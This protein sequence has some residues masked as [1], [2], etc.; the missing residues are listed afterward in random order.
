MGAGFSTVTPSGGS[1]NA[2]SVAQAVWSYSPRSLTDIQS[3]TAAIQN[4]DPGAVPSY[5]D[6]QYVP[7]P[8]Y[9]G[10]VSLTQVAAFMD[11]AIRNYN[12]AGAFANYIT[13]NPYN[14]WPPNAVGAFL[15]SLNMSQTSVALLLAY[16]G[17]TQMGQALSYLS[18]NYTN[19]AAVFNIVSPSTGATVMANMNAS[20]AAIILS[21]PVMSVTQAAMILANPVIP[22]AVGANILNVMA[23]GTAAIIFSNPNMSVTQAAMYLSNANMSVTQAA[24]ILS[25][26]NMP[27][28]Q[29]VSIVSIAV[30]YNVTQVAMELNLLSTSELINIA[31]NSNM[32]LTSLAAILSNAG[33]SANNAQLVLYYMAQNYYYNRWVNTITGNAGST[34]IATNVTI[35]SPLYSQNL[36]VASGV[37][38]TCGTQTCFF[39]AQS[40]N[41]YGTIVA[42]GATG[43]P[44][45]G[46]NIGNG[47]TGGGGIVVIAVTTTLGNLSVAGLPGGVGNSGATAA[48]GGGGGAGVFYVVTGVVVPVGGSGGG[49]SGYAGPAG[50][51]GGGGGG[52]GTYKGGG[53]GSA[54]LYAFASANS[55]LTYIMQGLSDWWLIKVLGKAPTSTTPL[56]YF[57]GSGGGS[58]GGVYTSY[59]PGGGGGGGGGG[60]VVVYAFDVV[61]GTI[62]AVGGTGGGSPGNGGGGGGGG[63]VFVFYG[64]TSGNLTA[65]V[66]GGIGGDIGGTGLAGANGTAYIAK[67]TVNG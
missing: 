44:S 7:V 2:T 5:S 65:S 38:V 13:N 41:N 3:L 62:N 59:Y 18:G 52:S 19:V 37:T 23:V 42:Y 12:M 66:N 36:T 49:L 39:V 51:N 56:I 10:Q 43:A 46:A 40:F 15:S 67:V 57:Y 6:L 4:N 24:Q 1:V 14:L 28:T 9:S 50:V 25:N 31:M 33:L 61:S 34:T 64:A 53:G 32:S 20:Q 16:T 17:A 55:M 45:P 22:A 54:T 26:A 30:N 48:S 63:L 29:V 60:E 35:S 58:G 11:N 27:I 8:Y 47:G 21:N